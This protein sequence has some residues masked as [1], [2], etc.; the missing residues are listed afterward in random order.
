MARRSMS[1]SMNL[2]ARQRKTLE[3]PI[4]A[5][6]ATSCVSV[7]DVP[8]PKSATR[9]TVKRVSRLRGFARCRAIR[10][11][12]D[13]NCVP[14]SPTLRRY[15]ELHGCGVEYVAQLDAPSRSLGGEGAMAGVSSASVLQDNRDRPVCHARTDGSA[16]GRNECLVRGTIHI[17][18][19]PILPVGYASGTAELGAPP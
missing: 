8:Y 13:G 16:P 3:L 1:L 19:P 11:V 5:N 14:S 2:I 6:F 7:P 15:S 10:D 17:A 12:L 9:G 4:P 18:R